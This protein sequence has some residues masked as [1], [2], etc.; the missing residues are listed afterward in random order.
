MAKFMRLSMTFAA[1]VFG[2]ACVMSLWRRHWTDAFMYFGACVF[3][4]TERYHY[5]RRPAER[6]SSASEE[7]G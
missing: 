1:T 3:A 4:A 5:Y 6:A 7:R 2:L